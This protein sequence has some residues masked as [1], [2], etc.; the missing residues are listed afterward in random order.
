MFLFRHVYIA[1]LLCYPWDVSVLFSVLHHMS[2]FFLSDFVWH[3]LVLFSIAM[4]D[5][6]D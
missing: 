5:S 1:V 6:A 2:E 3:V 4:Y